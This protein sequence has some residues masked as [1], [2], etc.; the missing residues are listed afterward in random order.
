MKKLKWYK[1]H[2]GI[3]RLSIAILGYK[4]FS[5]RLSCEWGW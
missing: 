1:L 2:I 5:I 3:F 4:K